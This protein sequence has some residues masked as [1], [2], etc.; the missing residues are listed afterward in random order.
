MQRAQYKP[1]PRNA[2][3]VNVTRSWLNAVG[4]Q[5]D[6]SAEPGCDLVILNAAGELL[7]IAIVN[8]LTDELPDIDDL[9]VVL[10]E[11]IGHYTTSKAVEAFHVITEV[12]GYGR[13]IPVDRGVAPSRKE[14]Y[15]NDFFLQA[16]RHREFRSAPDLPTTKRAEY[17]PIITRCSRAFFGKNARLCLAHSYQVDDLISYAWIWAHLYAHRYEVHKPTHKNGDDNARLLTAFLKHRFLEFKT[18]LLKQGKN[19]LPDADVAQIAMF[20]RVFDENDTIERY[21]VDPRKTLEDGIQRAEEEDDTE[22]EDVAARRRRA[23]AKVLKAN[24]A[25]LPHEEMVARL[26]RIAES[27]VHAYPTRKEARRQL[28][29]HSKTCAMCTEVGLSLKPL[30]GGREGEEVDVRRHENPASSDSSSVEEY[31]HDLFG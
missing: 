21:S 8:S 26:K 13:P 22:D 29:N 23:A 12:A 18:L 31:G 2:G 17:A 16:A 11:E 10:A 25:A 5:A 30:T 24:L 19:V 9:L 3:A 7:H 14:I 6:D 28:I 15:G 27:T 4:I 1:R 20:G